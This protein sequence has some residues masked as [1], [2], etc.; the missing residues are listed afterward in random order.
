MSMSA[1]V[2]VRTFPKETDQAEIVEFLI[3]SGLSESHKDSISFKPNGSVIIDKLQ[4][5]ECA[6]LIEA[7]HNKFNFGR[8]L[9]CNGIVPRTPDKNEQT[10]DTPA[11][12]SPGVSQATT[13]TSTGARPAD[14][15]SMS[16]QTI[17]TSPAMT[18]TTSSLSTTPIMVPSSESPQI[19][20]SLP[21][22]VSPMS[23]NTF[24]QQ[25]SE[26]PDMLHLQLSNDD[27]V[28]RNSLSLRSPPAGSL[29][30]EILTTGTATSDQ[31]YAQANRIQS[32][33]KEMSERYSDFGSC[34]SSSS[35]LRSW[36][37]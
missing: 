12:S 19:P 24:T 5:S 21:S 34:Y 36:C 15:H 18:T 8:R 30:A 3:L 4:S 29:A 37:R 35:G 28:R 33:L 13:V 6:V 16:P 17:P 9:Y 7:I 1:G 25:Y 32:S 10:E 20:P 22:L 23:P 27:L 2:S 11:S 31:H 26:T 14:S